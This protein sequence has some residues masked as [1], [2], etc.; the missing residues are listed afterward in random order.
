MTGQSSESCKHPNLPSDWGEYRNTIQRLYVTEDKSLPD[1]VDEMKATYNFI[2]TERQYKRRISEWHLDKNVKDDEMRAIIGKEAWRLQQGKKSTF[3][4]RDRLVD[5]KKIDRFAQRKRIDRNALHGVHGTLPASVRCTTPPADDPATLIITTE[6]QPKR[7]AQHDHTSQIKSNK[8][9]RDLG[10]MIG[11]S[12][13]PIDYSSTSVAGDVDSTRLAPLPA[14]SPTRSNNFGN[15]NTTS[16]LPALER[17]IQKNDPGSERHSEEL[18][19]RFDSLEAKLPPSNTQGTTS[20]ASTQRPYV[21]PEGTTASPTNQ[22]DWNP[23]TVFSQWNE[24]FERPQSAMSNTTQIPSVAVSTVPTTADIQSFHRASSPASTS[25]TSD[26]SDI[27]GQKRQQQTMSDLKERQYATSKLTISDLLQAAKESQPSGQ[28][29][30][31]K[32]DRTISD[33][34]QDKLYNSSIT[35][36]TPPQ[37][38]QQCIPQGTLTPQE[39]SVPTVLLQAAQHRHFMSRSPSPVMRSPL[40]HASPYAPERSS[41]S[42]PKSAAHLKEQQKAEEYARAL[43]EQWPKPSDLVI[44]RTISPKELALDHNE[45]EE[46]TKMPLFNQDKHE[47]HYVGTRTSD[48]VAPETPSRPHSHGSSS[49]VESPEI[50]RSTPVID[51]HEQEQQALTISSQKQQYV[52]SESTPNPQSDRFPIAII[53]NHCLPDDDLPKSVG[54]Y[55]FSTAGQY[56][57]SVLRWTHEEAPLALDK[58]SFYAPPIAISLLSLPEALRQRPTD[59]FYFQFFLDNTARQLVP[60]HCALNVFRKILPGMALRHEN[61]L[62][63]LLSYSA[64]HRAHLLGYPQPAARIAMWTR[65][66]FPDLRHAL[67]NAHDVSL[68]HLAISIMLTSMA[69]VLPDALGPQITWRESLRAANLVFN[70]GIDETADDEEMWFLH[71]WLNHI[72][73][74]S[75]ISHPEGTDE[76]R[77]LEV[78]ISQYGQPTTNKIRVDCL[79][80]CTR[81][82]AET[83]FEVSQLISASRSLDPFGISTQDEENTSDRVLSFHVRSQ[84]REML[85]QR[86]AIIISHLQDSINQT[87]MHTRC[88]KPDSMHGMEARVMQK[89]MSQATLVNVYR[90]IERCPTSHPSVQYYVRSILETLELIQPNDQ[91]ESGIL[92]PLFIAG[93]EVR[94]AIQQEMISMRFDKLEKLGMAQVGDVIFWVLEK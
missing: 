30:I 58:E 70:A 18:D 82:L 92:F 66:V 44:P 68:I 24:A 76:H 40:T 84:D 49:Q 15:H 53:V 51:G 43:A 81:E 67:S 16:R 8:R 83:I 17:Q 37:Q 77:P 47:Y 4:V 31:K 55:S 38:P 57:S 41:Y 86:T 10:D 65:D 9:T 1:V 73:L 27:D 46:D 56:E 33:I 2:A 13:A 72:N 88:R 29:N 26:L 74:I 23:G 61:L 75:A 71:Q 7:R 62:G 32:L 35:M 12:V 80:G 25:E 91:L 69:I 64:S 6:E 3:Y 45:A 11:T 21:R 85:Q 93:C 36:S 89:L 34:Y 14:L 78:K 60:H 79:S 48:T 28:G 87:D 5:R 63:L 94:T 22:P 42:T 54:V 39:N 20:R 59:A 90:R 19:R 52:P 50:L